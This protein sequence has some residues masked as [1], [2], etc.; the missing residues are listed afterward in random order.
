[1]ISLKS[2]LQL[3]NQIQRRLINHCHGSVNIFFLLHKLLLSKI[4]I[5][6][7]RMILARCV[8]FYFRLK[9]RQTFTP[10][11]ASKLH[12][13]LYDTRDDITNL[14]LSATSRLRALMTFSFHNLIYARACSSCESVIVRTT[15]HNKNLFAQVGG[16]G[17]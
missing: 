15:R 17:C 12:A 5:H 13:F 1:M 8:E 2:F 11:K 9:I 10:K 16:V 7:F 6:I 14:P 4:R 3:W